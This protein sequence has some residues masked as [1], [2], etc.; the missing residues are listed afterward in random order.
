MKVWDRWVK[1]SNAHLSRR[2]MKMFIVW[3]G[4]YSKT[5]CCI[6]LESRGSAVVALTCLNNLKC[7]AV[8]FFKSLT[9]FQ[10]SFYIPQ[11]RHQPIATQCDRRLTVLTQCLLP[12]K[13]NWES[14]MKFSTFWRS[15]VFFNSTLEKTRDLIKFQSKAYLLVINY[16]HLTPL[17]LP[18][19][20]L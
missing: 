10:M 13:Q 9:A 4:S 2:W 5:F 19:P 1:R 6:N 15:R 3:S 17:P 11:N 18:P 20:F 8:R 7:Y 16:L 14:R 12:N